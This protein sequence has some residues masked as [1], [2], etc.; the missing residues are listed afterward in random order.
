VFCS[1]KVDEAGKII[2]AALFSLNPAE[3]GAV[4]SRTCGAFNI[5]PKGKKEKG[6]EQA[7]GKAKAK[8][9]AKATAV[10]K[11][12]ENELISSTLLGSLLKSSSA[13]LNKVMKDPKLKMNSDSAHFHSS[14][15]QAKRT[16]QEFIKENND[17]ENLVKEKL[18]TL[19]EAVDPPTANYLF[20]TGVKIWKSTSSSKN[21]VQVIQCLRH[22]GPAYEIDQSLWES[23]SR[24]PF[25]P[26]DHLRA[27]TTEEQ[28]DFKAKQKARKE[29]SKAKAKTSAA[30]A[31]EGDAEPMDLGISS[32][33]SRPI[34]TVEAKGEALALLDAPNRRT[35]RSKSQEPPDK[36]ARTSSGKTP[37]GKKTAD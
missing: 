1:K 9:K 3:R 11:K 5:H 16:V 8:P 35:T 12:P 6:Q 17:N 24:D 32:E 25:H 19:G 29:A 2:F 31:A 20:A 15:V 36:K 30:P 27:S 14:L 22:R 18:A 37:K 13:L 4:L 33:R 28:E 26:D 10:P 34:L 7:E 21:V 23:S